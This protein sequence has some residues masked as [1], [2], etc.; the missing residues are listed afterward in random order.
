MRK[1]VLMSPGLCPVTID[2]AVC[3]RSPR[4]PPGWP[5]SAGSPHEPSPPRRLSA[6][7]QP[8]RFECFSPCSEAPDLHKFWAQNRSFLGLAL[9]GGGVYPGHFL[10]CCY[11]AIWGPQWTPFRWE[12]DPKSYPWLPEGP[13]GCGCIRVIVP[14]AILM[15]KAGHTPVLWDL[16]LGP[17]Y[18]VPWGPGPC[19]TYWLCPVIQQGVEDSLSLDLIFSSQQAFCFVPQLAELG[20][21]KKQ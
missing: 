3:R 4:V 10:F 13:S 11:L 17:P 15:L 21:G 9:A 5:L 8:W 18:P 14:P 2:S 20:K 1:T 6:Y 7:S 16:A 12:K 19:H